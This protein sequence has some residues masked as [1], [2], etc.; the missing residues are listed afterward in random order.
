MSKDNTELLAIDCAKL[1]AE[2]V[3]EF[4]SCMADVIGRGPGSDSEFIQ[5]LGLD[6]AAPLKFLLGWPADKLTPEKQRLC[7][8]N[9]AVALDL[10]YAPRPEIWTS[11]PNWR[12]LNPKAAEFDPE[13][14]VLDTDF[15][16][17]FPVAQAA[18]REVFCSG[19]IIDR[20]RRGKSSRA[21]HVRAL[22]ALW[23]F[24]FPD[25][26]QFFRLKGP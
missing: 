20:A 24:G 6:H 15:I 4:L 17:S 9:L 10:P 2:E 25:P 12:P 3:H 23:V 21:D 11:T 22:Y 19:N 14:S 1:N 16:K 18:W 13:R 26:G 5:R 7:E 8:F